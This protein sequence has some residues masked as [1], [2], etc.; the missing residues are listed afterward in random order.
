MSPK[1]QCPYCEHGLTP[2]EIGT[3]SARLGRVENSHRKTGRYGGAKIATSEVEKI[4]KSKKPTREIAGKYN[5]SFHTIWR[6]RNNKTYTGETALNCPHCGHELAPS[7]VKRLFGVFMGSRT[8]PLKTQSSRTTIK[9]ARQFATKLTW[10]DV[11]YIRK[12][13]LSTTELARKYGV[14]YM[15]I[16]DV[17]KFNSWKRKPEE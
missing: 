5:V 4:R 2:Q 6:I 1:I 12:S 15:A 8:S 3:L 17:R 11:V 9:Y 10:K 7:E 14:T 16:W 13:K